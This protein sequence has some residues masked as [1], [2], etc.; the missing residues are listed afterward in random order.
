M[1]HF[2]RTSAYRVLHL[3]AFGFLMWLA[4]RRAAGLV[5]MT[6]QPELDAVDDFTA[7]SAAYLLPCA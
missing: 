1:D 3:K 6:C 4:L 2:S 7:A 5:N